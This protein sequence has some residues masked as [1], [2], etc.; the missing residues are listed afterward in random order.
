MRLKTLYSYQTP[1]AGSFLLG[2]Q[3]VWSRDLHFTRNIPG[4]VRVLQGK[5]KIVQNQRDMGRAIFPLLLQLFVTR[6]L[7]H[8]KPFPLIH[9]LLSLDKTPVPWNCQCISHL[10]WA[11]STVKDMKDGS[12]RPGHM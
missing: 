9:L 6:S 2:C 11:M 4:K 3:Y 8:R 12:A 7:K 10:Q 5:H 1:T